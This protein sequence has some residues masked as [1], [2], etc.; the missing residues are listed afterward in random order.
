[1][2]ALEQD[3]RDR[4]A[5]DLVPSEIL[6]RRAKEWAEAVADGLRPPPLS[7]VLDLLA[8]EG[9]PYRQLVVASFRSDRP[10]PP[11]G[12]AWRSAGSSWENLL[13]PALRSVGGARIATHDGGR[14]WVLMA[15]ESQESALRPVL[16]KLS[17]RDRVRREVLERVN[18]ARRAEGLRPLTSNV[19]LDRTAQKYAELLAETGHYGHVGPEGRALDARLAREGYRY[20]TAGE[21][22]A[23]GPE[24]AEEVV[25]GWLASP[26]HR[27]NILGERFRETGLG[28]AWG[29]AWIARAT[30]SAMRTWPERRRTAAYWSR[31]GTTTR[32]NPPPFCTSPNGR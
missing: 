1:M 29:P 20:R 31:W 19:F 15:G 9:S 16:E 23:R 13:D 11:D 2:A 14:V 12:E 24:T 21:N 22:L 26:E 30:F 27:E 17:D 3:R 28:V 18:D 5:D 7:E 6:N 10:D 32:V 25:S 8:V 4:G